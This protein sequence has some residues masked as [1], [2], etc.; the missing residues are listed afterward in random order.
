MTNS[1][2]QRRINKA[3][4]EDNTILVHRSSIMKERPHALEY[5]EYLG[6]RKADLRKLESAGLAVRG[7]CKV[8]KEFKM[9][10]MLITDTDDTNSVLP[11]GEENV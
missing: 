9:G 5:M 7:L 8:G 6:L 11:S 3:L 2:L 10:W 4:T 1:A